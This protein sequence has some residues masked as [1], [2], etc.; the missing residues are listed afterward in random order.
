MKD[1]AT[2]IGKSASA[3]HAETSLTKDGLMPE[4]GDP[5]FAAKDGDIIP[6]IKT[7]LG[8]HVIRVVRGEAAHTEAFEKVA[9]KIRTSLQNEKNGDALYD[10]TT[11]I[12]DRLAT[13]ESFE[14]IAKDYK[15]QILTVK[16]LTTK[17][18][19]TKDLGFAGKNAQAVLAKIFE[20]KEQEPS[21]L[22]DAGDGKLYTLRVDKISPAT[23]KPYETVAE[24]IR[25]RWIAESKADQNLTILQKQA[26]SI[27]AGTVK[28]DSLNGKVERGISVSRTSIDK[29][30]L[31]RDVAMRLI[32][33]DTDKV[34]LAISR[35]KNGIYLAKITDVKLGNATLD[36][37]MREQ[38]EKLAA[39]SN[40]DM[41]I[42]SVEDDHNISINRDLLARTYGRDTSTTDE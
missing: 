7:P 14:D 27:N 35:E 2:E 5:V 12:E 37:A 21:S 40:V 6:A 9:D 33:A 30:S 17:T 18:D 25:A 42:Q 22:S 10:A 34:V 38:A 11:A 13:G 24:D 23:A 15:V 3:Y 26:E 41:F 39:N 1:A 19:P 31:P 28:F 8:W 29:G 16:N 36:S 20:S 32:E 4:I